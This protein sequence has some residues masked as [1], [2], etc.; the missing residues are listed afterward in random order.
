MA[1]GPHAPGADA[2][3]GRCGQLLLA[4]L[5]HELGPLALG[6]PADRLDGEIRHWFRIRFVFTRPYLG[7]ASS[8]SITLAVRTYSGGS[9]SRVWILT[10]P[11]FRSRFSWRPLGADVV[12]PFQGFHPLVQ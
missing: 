9:S 7:T 2:A 8:M 12:G 11:A 5:R 4:Q 1:P 10:F 6:E 3:D